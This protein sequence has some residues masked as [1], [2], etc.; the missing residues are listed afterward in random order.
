[1]DGWLKGRQGLSSCKAGGSEV[2]LVFTAAV[3]LL[4]ATAVATATKLKLQSHESCG[5]I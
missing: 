1:M 2:V 4:A 5:S 3:A